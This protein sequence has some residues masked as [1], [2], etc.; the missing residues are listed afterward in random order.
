[1]GL[2]ATGS[3]Q[4]GRGDMTQ[5]PKNAGAKKY[6]GGLDNSGNIE[7]RYEGTDMFLGRRALPRDC[8]AL[9]IFMAAEPR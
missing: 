8:S 4:T 2:N 1:M 5:C 7:G 6:A 9:A 3:R